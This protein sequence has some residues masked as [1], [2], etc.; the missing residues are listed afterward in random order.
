VTTRD[1][2]R[3]PA[4]TVLDLANLEARLPELR[5][6]YRSAAPFPHIM[7]D[8]FLVPDV[9]RRAIEEFPPVDPE[10]WINYVH[11][12]ERKFGNTNPRSWGPT[13][14]AVATG[15]TAE[16]FVRFLEEL[17]GIESLIVDDAFEGG[18]LHQSLTGGFLNVHA[19][20]TVHPQHRHWRRR[21]NVLVYLNDEWPAA[22]GGDLELWSI[23]MKRCVETIAP[24]GNRA[25]IFTTDAD[26]FHGHPDPLRCPPGVARQ[27]MA[28]YYFTAEDEP[29]VRSTEYR[30]RPGDG[31]RSVLIYLDK[32]V[33]RNY[34]RVKRRLGLSDDFA[35]RFLNRLQ[36][37]RPRGNR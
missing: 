30:A 26:S 21:V 23:D 13:L 11:V 28:L 14:Q 5:D 6:Q 19:D 17:T 36:R 16:P 27:S 34:D 15:L 35:S 9:A 37:L 33:V 10:R 20:F 25:V 18:G 29:M 1:T 32:Q 24:V 4:S 22:Y 3:P 8:D 7:L 2:N 12:N 31:P